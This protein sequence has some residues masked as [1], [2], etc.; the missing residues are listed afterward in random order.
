VKQLFGDCGNI[1]DIRWIK[2]G[3]R[4]KGCGFVQFDK[5][6]STDKAV[7][8]TVTIDGRQL[9]VDFANPSKHDKD[10]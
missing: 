4:F 6:E 9:R 7:G 5:T 10:E 1:V 3:N 8:K 2:R